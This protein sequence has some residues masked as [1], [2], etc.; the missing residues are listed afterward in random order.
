MKEKYNRYNVNS[1]L[2]K[3]VIIRIDY[4]GMTAVDS[5][6]TQLKNH[7][8]GNF[9]RYS[10]TYLSSSQVRNYRIGEVMDSLNLPDQAIFNEPLHSFSDIALGGHEDMVR[11]QN[12]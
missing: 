10:R 5:W 2:F 6:V 11:Y 12:L 9:Q 8:F 7:N 3:R 4:Q 1:E